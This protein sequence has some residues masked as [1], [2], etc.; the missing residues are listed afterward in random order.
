MLVVVMV[1]IVMSRSILPVQ[2]FV[3]DETFREQLIP[4]MTHYISKYHIKTRY[5]QRQRVGWY[6]PGNNRHDA[7]LD[8]SFYRMEGKG[9]QRSRVMAQMMDTMHIPE[10]SFLVHQPMRPVK[11]SI[12]QQ[13]DKYNAACKINQRMIPQMEVHS[14]IAFSGGKDGTADNN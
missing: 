12:V 5:C 8:H 10:Y 6:Y 2:P 1:H 14:G 7:C 9:R 4:Q 3:P 11:I 13:D